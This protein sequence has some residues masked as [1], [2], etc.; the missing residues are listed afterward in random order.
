LNVRAGT[1]LNAPVL[2]RLPP[3][4]G[5]TVFCQAQGQLVAGTVTVSAIWDRIDAGSATGGAY[6]AD[7]FI[8]WPRGSRPA[9]PWCSVA[10][11]ALATTALNVRPSA[12][13][14][15]PAL[16]TVPG[17][18]VLAITCH[19]DGTQTSGTTGVSSRWDRTS[20]GGFVADAFVGWPGGRNAVPWCV[21]TPPAASGTF[22]AMTA[23]LAQAGQRAYHV[24]AAV[25]LAQAILESGWGLS[26][27]TEQG[28][29]YFGMKCFGSPGAYALGCRPFGTTECGASCAATTAEFRVYASP[30]GSF[31][32]HAVALATLPRYA[33]AMRHADNPDQFARD[34]AAAGYATDPNYAQDLIA[35]MHSYDLYRFDVPNAA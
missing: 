15:R 30:A 17:G 28:S 7:A 10:A 18:A 2:R 20:D 22:L 27:L 11:T 29:A 12:S 25:T 23:P 6:V 9:V 21:L 33:G 14:M 32:D 5:V 16:H 4:A 1:T 13:T 26:G 31:T 3:G 24:P 35:L 19:L 34:L 8:A